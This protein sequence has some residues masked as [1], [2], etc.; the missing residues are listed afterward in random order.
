MKVSLLVERSK[1]IS[2]HRILHADRE[3]V[4]YRYELDSGL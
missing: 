4:L 2:L 1:Y 3:S